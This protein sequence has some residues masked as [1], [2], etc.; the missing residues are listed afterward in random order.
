MEK[1]AAAKREWM[2]GLDGQCS[3]HVLIDDNEAARGIE[4]DDPAID[5]VL[6]QP[7]A[8][9]KTRQAIVAALQGC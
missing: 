6:P 8:W 2:R 9:Q 5:H 1:A 3:R 7:F 4:G